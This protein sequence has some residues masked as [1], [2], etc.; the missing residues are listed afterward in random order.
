MAALPVL[1]DRRQLAPLST[2]SP[3]WLAKQKSLQPRRA[4]RLDV[5]H[6]MR[7]L[8]ITTTDALR[9]VNHRAVIVWERLQHEQEGAAASTVRH[10]L[11]ALVECNRGSGQRPSY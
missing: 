3:P 7:A 11:A 9:Q 10:R 6:F 4:Y 2:S 5:R 1:V 8:G